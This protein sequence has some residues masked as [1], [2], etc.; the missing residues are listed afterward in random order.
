MVR[1]FFKRLRDLFLQLNLYRTGSNDATVCYR[2]RLSTRIYCGLMG[3]I[4][5]AVAVAV[6]VVPRQIFTV[7]DA[8]SVSNFQHLI[9]Q[10]PST[11]RCPCT[12]A[13]VA[14]NSFVAIHV[15]FHQVCSSEFIQQTWIEALLDQRN[16]SVRT[17]HDVRSTLLFFWQAIRGFCAVSHQA[18]LDTLNAFGQLRV[19]TSTAASLETL[20]VASEAALNQSLNEVAARLLHNLFFIQRGIAGNQLASAAET[21]YRLRY[22]PFNGTDFTAPTMFPRYYG[23]CS[24]LNMKGCPHQATIIIGRNRSAPVPGM[25][26]D[27]LIIDGVLASTLECYYDQECILLLHDELPNQAQT[28]SADL[29]KYFSTNATVLSLLSRLMIDQL[30]MEISIAQ[31]FA[32][33]KPLYCSYTQTKVFDILFIVTAIIGIF[34]G[35][36]FF[37][38][39]LAPYIT[40]IILYRSSRRSA[41]IAFSAESTTPNMNA[42]K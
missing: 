37:L 35:L 12:K 21:N 36:S 33:C 42:S 20:T 41:V 27:C 34:G 7:Q 39:Q 40:A 29:N 26:A 9:A 8:P 10:Y 24:C 15:G 25:I 38:K 1:V 32:Q 5:I 13:V 18:W 3:G 2:Q 28:L 23:N 31:F 19:F 6:S 16:V 14:Y 4:L 17:A 22:P 30:E 11:L